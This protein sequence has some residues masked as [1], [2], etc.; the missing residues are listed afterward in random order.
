MRERKYP[1]C[2]GEGKK[3]AIE[4]ENIPFREILEIF[5]SHSFDAI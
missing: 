1:H 4:I 2:L 5:F 3:V